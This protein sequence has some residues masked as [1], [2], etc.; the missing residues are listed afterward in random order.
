MDTCTR[1]D[2]AQAGY[3]THHVGKWDAGMATPT[4]TPHGRGYDSSLNYFGHGNWAWS[5]GEWGGSTD[6]QQ[7]SVGRKRSLGGGVIMARSLA[8]PAHLLAALAQIP[9]RFLSLP[10]AMPRPGFVDLWDT[11]GPARSLRGTGHEELL[12]TTTTTTMMIAMTTTT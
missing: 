1:G 3:A 9:S 12:T 4:H 7:A 5:E 11:D 8:P 2:A 10:Q 6:H